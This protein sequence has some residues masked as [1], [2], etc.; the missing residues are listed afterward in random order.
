MKRTTRFTVDTG[1]LVVFK[2]LGLSPAEIL[3]RADLPGDLFSRKTAS[4]GIEEYFRFWYALEKSINNP[5][6]PLVLGQALPVES[7]NPPIFAAFCSPNL[8]V[9]VDRLSRFKMLIGPM[10]LN[11]YKGDLETIIEFDCLGTDVPLPPLL[12]ATELVFIVYLVRLATRERINPTA[13][14]TQTQLDKKAYFDFFGVTPKSGN[15]NRITFS[16]KDAQSPFLTENESMW[17]F[18]E[19]ELRQRL[20]DLDMDAGFASRVRSALLEMLPSGKI[21]I[22]DTANKLGISKRTLQRRLSEEETTFQKELNSTREGLARHY[23]VNSQISSAEI[24]FLIGFDDPSSFIRAF[25]IW[26]GKTPE[27]FR[28]ESIGQQH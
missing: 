18:F 5:T 1:W 15:Q 21:S 14:T 24:S 7:F 12:V 4:L 11:V 16:Q 19:P 17:N 20:A 3:K 28:K 22:L 9:C 25:H 27:C 23:L 26:T 10:V 2:D 13:V 8:N 6:V